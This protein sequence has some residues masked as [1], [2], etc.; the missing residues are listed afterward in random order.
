MGKKGE[1]ASEKE[2]RMGMVGTAETCVLES[3]ERCDR[4]FGSGQSNFAYTGRVE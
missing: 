4:V 3:M 1:K 2:I